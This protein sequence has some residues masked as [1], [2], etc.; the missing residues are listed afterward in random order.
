MFA[1][2]AALRSPALRRGIHTG[3]KTST[4]RSSLVTSGVVL[5]AGLGAYAAFHS[6][7]AGNRSRRAIPTEAEKKP[8][9]ATTERKAPVRKSQ[10]TSS[11]DDST[12]AK[13]SPSEPGVLTPTKPTPKPKSK[14]PT[15]PE[16]D[17][18]PSTDA[19]SKP[20][21]DEASTT[22]DE[23]K[24]LDEEASNQGAY[25]PET[26]EINWDCPCLGGMAHGP[27]GPQFR[28]AFSC[29]IHSEEEPKGVDCVEKFKAMQD[30]F[31][32]HPDVYGEEIDDEDEGEKDEGAASPEGEQKPEESSSDET[33]KPES[34]PEEEAT[35]EPKPESKK[36]SLSNQPPSK[37]TPSS[38]DAPPTP[39]SS[40]S[41]RKSAPTANVSAEETP[42]KKH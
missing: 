14:P 25:N 19:D 34:Q 26:G 24:D 31:R 39:S 13:P 36:P 5:A 4:G 8:R 37:H 21:P 22:S 38:S 28:E 40:P 11:V 2:R 27:C 20:T 17:S 9:I 42:S 18:K 29:F 7:D 6:W 30:C 23:L 32:E 10:N 33:K 3:P 15:D 35:Q 41:S 16:S 1:A 12:P